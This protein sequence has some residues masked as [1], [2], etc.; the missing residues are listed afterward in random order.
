MLLEEFINLSNNVTSVDELFELMQLAL[1][2]IGINQIVFSLMTNHVALNKP[3]GHGLLV[4]YPEDWMKYYAEQG[5]ETL[6]PVRHAMFAATGP[7]AWDN[8]L[9]K[10]VLTKRQKTFFGEAADA[11]LR[12]GFGIPLRGPRGALAGFGLASN[13]RDLNFDQNALSYMNLVAQ[14]FYQVYH[15]LESV[16]QDDNVVYLSDREREILQWSANGKS[17]EDIGTILGITKNTVD[18]HLRNIYRKFDTN[19]IT[20][21]V[22]TALHNGL[23][24]Q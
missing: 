12:I 14:Q 24:Q 5:Y 16:A 10:L 8:L 23:I 3:A 22:L 17:R 18:F 1:Q 6:D 13:T 21:A 7:F 9:D 20:V 11:G 15:S 4:N 19:N 2:A